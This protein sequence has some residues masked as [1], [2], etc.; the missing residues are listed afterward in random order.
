MESPKGNFSFR[1]TF[2]QL[3]DR[4]EPVV[5]SVIYICGWSA[6]L[7]VIAIFSFVFI[8]SLPA[9]TGIE[10]E[11]AAGEIEVEQLDLGEFTTSPRW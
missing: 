3:Q 1:H 6:I 4:L 9:L 7:F 5:V 11:I 8:E 10:T 2:Q